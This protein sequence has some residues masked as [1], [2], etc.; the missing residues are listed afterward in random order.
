MAALEAAQQQL[1]AAV[2]RLESVIGR[3]VE[4]D[5]GRGT[6]GAQD[7]RDQEILREECHRL[8]VELEAANATNQ[9]L[10]AAV[11]EAEERLRAVMTRLDAVTGG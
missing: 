8:R 11:D 4:R 1:E 5:R 10:S 9:R 3:N 6:Q 2:A 7:L